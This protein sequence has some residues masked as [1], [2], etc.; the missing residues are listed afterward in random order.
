MNPGTPPLSV[1][2]TRYRGTIE[3]HGV[4]GLLYVI[5]PVKLDEYLFGVVPSEM[6]PGWPLEAMKSQAVA[7]RTYAYYH[8]MKHKNLLDDLDATTNSQVYKGIGAEKENSNNAV[9][10]TAG[11][12]ITHKGSPILSYFHS[13]CG[14][15]T[16]DDA[17]LGASRTCRTSPGQCARTAPTLQSSAG[18]TGWG[19]AKSSRR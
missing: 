13:T 14:G 4:T 19:S 11:E 9:I 17:R 12:I 15:H 6:P 1:N 18:S 3:L 8:I 7:A 5:N 16:I 10:S 2:G